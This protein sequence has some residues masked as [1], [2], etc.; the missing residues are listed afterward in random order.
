MGTSWRNVIC[1]N[2]DITSV[3]ICLIVCITVDSHNPSGL[4]SGSP[5]SDFCVLREK[6]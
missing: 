1:N 6:P 4:V 3:G 2:L 5:G